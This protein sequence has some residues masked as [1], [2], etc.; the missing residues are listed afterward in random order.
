MVDFHRG[1]NHSTNVPLLNKALIAFFSPSELV[2]RGQRGS[3]WPLAP[4]HVLLCWWYP[5]LEIH[6]KCVPLRGEA[7]VGRK[8]HSGRRP[9]LT[10]QSQLSTSAPRPHLTHGQNEDPRA[11]FW[12]FDSPQGTNHSANAP[13]LS[14]ATLAFCSSSS[15]VSIG[16]RA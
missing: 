6:S 15:L 13:L 2:S 3:G 8:M 16:Q 12:N 14:K 9:Q 4:W 5:E 10:P 1:T 11:T 7:G